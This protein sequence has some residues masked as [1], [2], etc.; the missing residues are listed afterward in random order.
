LEEEVTEGDLILK[1]RIRERQRKG[2]DGERR[3]VCNMVTLNKLIGH[4]F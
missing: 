4:T 2:R 3:K 1:I